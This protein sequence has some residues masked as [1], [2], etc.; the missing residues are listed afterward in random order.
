MVVGRYTTP[1]VVP[2]FHHNVF[3]SLFLLFLSPFPALAWERSFSVLYPLQ[4]TYGKLSLFLV[5]LP[6]VGVVGVGMGGWKGVEV[7]KKKE[8]W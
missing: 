7:Y 6:W 8:G 1:G 5:C 4:A 2:R 3:S